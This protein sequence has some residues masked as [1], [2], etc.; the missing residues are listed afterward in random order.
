[1]FSSLLSV[2]IIQ[3]KRR[4]K[5]SQRFHLTKDLQKCRK[6]RNLKSPEPDEIQRRFEKSASPRGRGAFPR[7]S[8]HDSNEATPLRKVLNLSREP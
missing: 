7:E 6:S 2:H 3:Y 8:T 1:M 5:Q 4:G